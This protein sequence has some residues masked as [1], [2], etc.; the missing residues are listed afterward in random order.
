MRFFICIYVIPNNSSLY[1]NAVLSNASCMGE[2][3][4]C[5]Q[6]LARK[7]MGIYYCRDYGIYVRIIQCHCLK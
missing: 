5:I 3:G 1:P 6:N 4:N 2:I 7:L